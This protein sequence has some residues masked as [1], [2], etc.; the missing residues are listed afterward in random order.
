MKIILAQLF[1]FTVALIVF[2]SCKTERKPDVPNSVTY[3]SISVSSVYH[4]E[5]DSTK[6]SC[7]LKVKYL[8]PVNYADSQIV[9]K[10]QSELNFV[11]M[12][13]E[14]YE[15]LSPKDA[16]NQYVKDYI[17]NYK[18]DAK[19]QF[20]HW[21]ESGDGEDYFSYYK[22]LDSKVLFD[23]SGIISY[24]ISSMD[25]KG[26]ANSST[27]YRN[28]VIDLKTGNILSEQDIFVNEYKNVLNPL[29]IDKIMA[30]NKVRKPEDL[31]EF[32]YLG[33]E[34]LSSNNNFYVD[35]KGI[36]YIFNPGEYTVATLGELSIFLTY[37]EVYNI[38]KSN[39]PISILTGK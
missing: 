16:V 2:F 39:S 22:T 5:N 13:D 31:L 18:N 32:G 26:G 38:L 10:V 11:L 14:K 27:A 1:V 3:D 35:A 28:V 20:P 25:Y 7:S 34:D 23:K 6:P 9:A 19:E 12:E 30:K 24:Q 17:E 4:L 21:Q 33:V 29:I 15:K 36:T 37:E 8:F